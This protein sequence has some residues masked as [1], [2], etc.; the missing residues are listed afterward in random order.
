M[1]RFKSVNGV[2]EPVDET[3]KKELKE[4]GIDHLGIPI[5]QDPD[6]QM[7]AARM[8]KSVEEFIAIHSPAKPAVK[9]EPKPKKTWKKVKNVADVSGSSDGN[10]T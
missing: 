5:Q 10:K 1:P 3:A 9:V 8:G 2:W 6:L 4:K 7:R